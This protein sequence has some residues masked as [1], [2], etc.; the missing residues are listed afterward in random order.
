MSTLQFKL[1][2]LVRSIP[3]ND[4][5]LRSCRK[6]QPHRAIHPLCSR[7]RPRATP[8][9]RSKGVAGEATKRGDR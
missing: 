7:R 4:I 6:S 3:N 2:L 8:G 5:E 9:R 1:I